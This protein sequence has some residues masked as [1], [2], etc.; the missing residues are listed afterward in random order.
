MGERTVNNINNNK[1]RNNILPCTAI[2][3]A[4]RNSRSTS[5]PAALNSA[6][7]AY[8]Q[9]AHP[10]HQSTHTADP[11]V[12]TH[13][14][15]HLHMSRVLVGAAGVGDDVEVALVRPGHNEIIDNPSFLSGEEGQR[16]LGG[17]ERESRAAEYVIIQ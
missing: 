10:S 5:K 11:S 2:S 3:A 14:H 16:A 12:C 1:Q 7:L 17:F 15:T 13:T 6:S 9:N 8:R 4:S